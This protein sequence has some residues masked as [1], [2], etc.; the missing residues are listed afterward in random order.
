MALNTAVFKTRALT[1][2]IFVLVMVG[3]LFIHAYTFFA[4]IL[5]IHCG[6]WWEYFNLCDKINNTH[7]SPLVRVGFIC[8][9]I[10]FLLWATQDVF[11]LD[12]LYLFENFGIL[13]SIAG[14]AL[15]SIGIFKSTIAKWNDIV[16][17]LIGF[18]YIGVSC[19][20]LVY[21]ASTRFYSGSINTWL[22]YGILLPCFVIACMWINDTMAYLVGSF[23]GKTPLSKIS[24]KKTW[25]GIFLGAVLVGFAMY[26][27]DNAFYFNLTLMS[28]I[29]LAFIAAIL[30]TIGDLVESKLKRV[31]NVK[32]SG[33]FMPG[34]GGFL[35]RFDSLLFATP[36]MGVLFY[37]ILR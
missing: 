31:A 29:L 30:G 28:W 33:S 26:K 16:L 9:G 7:L 5:L 1:A 27:I 22:P 15:S 8:L 23:I 13:F 21:L 32:D 4:L 34:H 3:G 12:E 19:A 10:T 35:D 14:F 18:A 24:P 25:E 11:A 20:V 37:F 17:P 36:I 6:A 2:F